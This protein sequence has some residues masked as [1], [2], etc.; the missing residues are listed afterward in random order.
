MYY[1]INIAKKDKE[2][3]KH[4]FATAP[5][6]LTHEDEF[7]LVLKDLTAKFPEPEFNITATYNPESG[8]ILDV[9][10]LLKKFDLV[11]T[12]TKVYLNVQEMQYLV[13]GEG[14]PV[15]VI[16]FDEWEEWN[17]VN[18]MGGLPL[19]DV[20]IWAEDMPKTTATD[21]QEVHYGFQYVN[22]VPSENEGVLQQGDDWLNADELIVTEEPIAQL[23]IKMFNASKGKEA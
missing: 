3:Y 15:Q 7:L 17:T 14:L 13:I 10:E 1:E 5:R 23:I 22:L 12:I 6:S 4:Y 20:Q 16:R 18:G 9:K 21:S 19:F 8:K 2:G 11:P